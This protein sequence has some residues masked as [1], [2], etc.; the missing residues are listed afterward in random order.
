M[1]LSSANLIWQRTSPVAVVFFLLNSVRQIITNGLPAMAVVVAAFV[2]VSDT[3][4]SWMLTGLLGFA[5]LTTIG[6]I[7]NWVRY[8]FCVNDDKVLV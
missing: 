5:L 3:N 2:S 4:K 8:R 1:S 7:L 6:A